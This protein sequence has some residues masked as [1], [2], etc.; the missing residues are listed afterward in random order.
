MS[1]SDPFGIEKAKGTLRIPKAP[2][3]AGGYA[4]RVVRGAKTK[5]HNATGKGAE[6]LSSPTGTRFGEYSEG[7]KDARREA[8][9]RNAEI[10]FAAGMI[11]GTATGFSVHGAQAGHDRR[12]YRQR[13]FAKARV[14]RITSLGTKAN[15]Q[16][17]RPGFRPI[18]LAAG[19]AVGGALG[20][21]A[22]VI[23]R[24]SAR[25]DLDAVYNRQEKRKA[26]AAAVAKARKKPEL[27][28]YTPDRNERTKMR[29]KRSAAFAAGGAGTMVGLKALERSQ[30]PK[31]YRNYHRPYKAKP[32]LIAAGVG[33]A[34]GA[35]GKL[36][37]EQYRVKK[38]DPFGI[39]K[40]WD[41]A[42]EAALTMGVLGGVTAGTEG[43]KRTYKRRKK[44]QV[45]AKKENKAKGAAIAA[46]GA[47]TLGGTAALPR[48]EHAIVRH[49]TGKIDAQIANLN[50]SK[51]VKTPS[52]N[53]NGQMMRTT[54]P[55]EKIARGVKLK[56][57]SGKVDELNRARKAIKRP[58]LAGNAKATW[59]G[60]AVGA[61]ALWYGSRHSVS[62]KETGHRRDVDA[63]LVG[64][65]VGAG[66]Y[67]EASYALKP[68][69]RRAEAKIK[70]NPDLNRQAREYQSK[71]R[72][73]NAK[74]G[75]PSWRPYFRNY[76]K[77]LP[78]SKLKRA[79]AIT[80]T[81]RSGG[82]LTA[83]AG[84]AAAVGAAAADRKFFRKPKDPVVAKFDQKPPPTNKRIA[85]QKK[86][87]AGFSLA[88]GTLGLAALGTRGKATALTRAA[89]TSANGPKLLSAAQKW[90]DRSTGLTTIGAGIGGV[91]AYNFASYTNAEAKAQAKK[92]GPVRKMDD[93]FGVS[94][95]RY[96]INEDADPDVKYKLDNAAGVAGAASAGGGVLAGMPVGEKL[97]DAMVSRKRGGKASYKAAALSGL[98]SKR[99]KAGGALVG[100]GIVGA[101]AVQHQ[102]KKKG[103]LVVKSDPFG[104][105]KGFRDE[106][107]KPWRDRG[108]NPKEEMKKP[109]SQRGPK[110]GGLVGRK[111]KGNLTPVS[112]LG[113]PKFRGHTYTGTE[114]NEKTGERKQY[115]PTHVN[116][117][118][119]GKSLILR[120]P[121]YA[122]DAYPG[123][124]KG[125]PKNKS[126]YLQRSPGKVKLTPKSVA[127]EVH[128]H[129]Q[130]GSSK[131]KVIGGMK[132]KVN[133]DKVKKD[134]FGVEKREGS[135]GRDV[136]AAAFPGWHGAIAGK[137]G[138]KLRSFGNEVAGTALGGA[139]GGIVGGALTG[140]R[141]T[142]VGIGVGSMAG[143]VA[144]SRRNQKRG[145]LKPIKKNYTDSAFG[146]VH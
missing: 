28:R 117:H 135:G 13:E 43:L 97:S 30:L 9:G 121:K 36:D 80:H 8:R 4:R 100:A 98:K 17:G 93:P 52:K 81:G 131:E 142:G 104:V 35:S 20:Y 139:A 125:S 144:G 107:K 74:A 27:E 133:Q 32:A 14:P 59:T 112:K 24:K 86:A 58:H 140:G 128:A 83:A 12:V 136:A 79:L 77:N 29:A 113:P 103:V 118:P 82:A 106:M 68:L 66:A 62:K 95:R 76:P 122:F 37:K 99:A 115:G 137:K 57:I 138:R 126:Q 49:K 46:G 40:G 22:S 31:A 87:Q 42:G 1:N 116:V 89:K 19:T 92:K 132:F 70:R 15:K 101:A 11:G 141:A 73:K 67:Q 56:E 34:I 119:K 3:K 72:P 33:A 41:R 96:Q 18:P 61:P 39:D 60:I 7:Q 109:W 48:V 90:K 65:A 47:A 108:L 44:L 23:G 146:I 91:G 69:D 25:Q 71:M 145:H 85:H 114:V 102:A 21:S 26:K 2:S 120:R 55:K 130:S 124:M 88:G 38:N 78:G 143:S 127:N 75:D 84:G 123:E 63:G 105:E 110:V 111:K 51:P 16:K 50:A 5:Y 129:A 64:G 6:N 134:A 45:V 10:G 94:K 54:S 53:V